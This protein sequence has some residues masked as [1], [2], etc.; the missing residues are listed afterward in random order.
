MGSLLLTKNRLATKNLNEKVGEYGIKRYTI[1]KV[2]MAKKMAK[3]KRI[4]YCKSSSYIK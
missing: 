3:K 2:K 4:T 1:K